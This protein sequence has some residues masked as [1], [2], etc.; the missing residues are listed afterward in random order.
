MMIKAQD[1]KSGAKRKNFVLKT[2][3]Y[4]KIKDSEENYSNMNNIENN[5]FINNY[6]NPNFI[7]KNIDEN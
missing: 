1:T 5:T 2:E 7:K 6:Y 4:K 3:F